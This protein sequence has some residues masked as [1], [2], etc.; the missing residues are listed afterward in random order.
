MVGHPDGC[1][2][3]FLTI[4]LLQGANAW[5]VGWFREQ[6]KLAEPGEGICRVCP[7]RV[8]A[9]QSLPPCEKKHPAIAVGL[10]LRLHV[11]LD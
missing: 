5:A 7:A 2:S 4:Y 10:E 1:N 8:Q 6:E 11:F 9:E 3:V